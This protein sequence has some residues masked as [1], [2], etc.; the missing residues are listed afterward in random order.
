MRQVF[1]ADSQM[2]GTT[3]QN[4]AACATWHPGIL[5]PHP[6]VHSISEGVYHVVSNR[7]KQMCLVINKV[8]CLL[9]SVGTEEFK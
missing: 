1:T 4:R 7:M 3:V 8:Y 5:H 2:L 6:N 9:S